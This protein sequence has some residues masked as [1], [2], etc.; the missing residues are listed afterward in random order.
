LYSNIKS[1]SNCEE[2]LEKINYKYS[3]VIVS[4][5]LSQDSV[6]ILD[7]Q[8]HFETFLPKFNK[9]K[10]IKST[11][12]LQRLIY[13]HQLSS[14]ESKTFK[15]DFD[16]EKN[17]EKFLT[18]QNFL[19][20]TLTSSEFFSKY[21][22][23]KEEK[24]KTCIIVFGNESRGISEYIRR[25]S[26]YKLIIP[27]YGHSDVSFNISVCCGMV[28]FNFLSNEFLPG[29]FLDH[30]AEDAI[31]ILLRSLINSLNNNHQKVTDILRKDNNIYDY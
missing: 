24:P 19:E 20:K 10:E 2:F 25:R 30:K 7:M 8:K 15:A 5:D 31:D 22:F 12:I 18:T 26:D 6:S 17:K 16:Y 27:Q 14:E 28:L 29:S 3:P 13:N 9:E 1:Y 23:N 11:E 4:T 21:D